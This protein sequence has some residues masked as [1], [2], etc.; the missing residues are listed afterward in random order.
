MTRIET[1][2][3]VGSFVLKTKI[4]IQY[5]LKIL[6]PKCA[7]KTR[8]RVKQARVCVF[9]TRMKYAHKLKSLVFMI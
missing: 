7:C 9:D 8:L 1:K 6:G 4:Y 2:K 3:L 5:R